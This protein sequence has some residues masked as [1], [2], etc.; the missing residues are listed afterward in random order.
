MSEDAAKFSWHL[1]WH[2][3][4]KPLVLKKYARDTLLMSS[5][6]HI[7]IVWHRDNDHKKVAL[8]DPNIGDAQPMFYYRC[9]YHQRILE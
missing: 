2:D 9:G 5:Q 7:K 4:R 3:L 6:K 8:Q 1:F